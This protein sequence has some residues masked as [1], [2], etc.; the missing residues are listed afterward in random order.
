MSSEIVFYTHPVCRGRVIRWMLEE[1]GQ[2]YRTEV[3]GA[4]T[5]MKDPVGDQSDGKGAGDRPWRHRRDRGAAICAYL[6]DAFPQANLAPPPGILAGP[7]LPLDVLLGRPAR[8][9]LSNRA[10]G[11]EFRPIAGG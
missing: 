11:F 3:L 7:L 1:L 9:G 8:S 2:P 5:S 4:G 10:A 6:A